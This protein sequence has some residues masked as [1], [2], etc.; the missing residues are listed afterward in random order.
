MFKGVAMMIE[1]P[2]DL[3][4]AK[5]HLGSERDRLDAEGVF[6]SKKGALDLQYL[7][8]ICRSCGVSNEL[9]SMM[10]MARKR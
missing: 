9:A 1:T 7:S 3:I 4:A 8:A 6:I 10:R 2:E 5:L